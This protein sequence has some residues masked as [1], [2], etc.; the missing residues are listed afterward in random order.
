[1]SE[2]SAAMVTKMIF[3]LSLDAAQKPY[4]CGSKN[5]Q[6]SALFATALLGLAPV[7]STRALPPNDRKSMSAYRC[8]ESVIAGSNLTSM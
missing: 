4:Y 8:D 6:A 5:P 2:Q 1:M 3:F 7:P